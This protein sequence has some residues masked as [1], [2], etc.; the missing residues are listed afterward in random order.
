MIAMGKAVEKFFRD[1]AEAEKNYRTSHDVK[2]LHQIT[3]LLTRLRDYPAPSLIAGLGKEL[4]VMNAAQVLRNTEQAAAQAKA[5]AAAQAAD[6]AA[7][8]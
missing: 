5:F 8:K 6:A 1:K 4:A 2:R 3:E 7:T